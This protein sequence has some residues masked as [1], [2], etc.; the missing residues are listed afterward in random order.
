MLAINMKTTPKVMEP[1][2]FF[3]ISANHTCFFL[4][5]SHSL[6]GYMISTVVNANIA[7]R[8]R[9][10]NRKLMVGNKGASHHPI[11]PNCSYRSNLKAISS[12]IVHD[13]QSTSSNIPVST[14]A[15]LIADQPGCI[16][17]LSEQNDSYLYE[18]DT[19]NLVLSANESDSSME[20]E[21]H[22]H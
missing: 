16:C 19:Y 14:S 6:L 7:Q 8:S 1:V 12:Q 9:Q 10:E 2:K 15:D 22:H 20:D 11:P 21:N 3:L 5:W 17:F 13:N 4:C 18:M